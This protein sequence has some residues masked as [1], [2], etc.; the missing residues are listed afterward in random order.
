MAVVEVVVATVGALVA[1]VVVFVALV[2]VLVAAVDVLVA[3][4]VFAV[5]LTVGRC[6][7]SW[8]EGF[9]V[10]FWNKGKMYVMSWSDREDDNGKQ[11]QEY[12]TF[13]LDHLKIIINFN[14]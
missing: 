11:S 6:E 10:F 12:Q 9:N 4:V 2:G 8:S 1:V 5:L 13:N 14:V 7:R 3:V